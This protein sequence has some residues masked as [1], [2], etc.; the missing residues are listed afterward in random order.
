MEKEA[1]TH[2]NIL[3]WTIPGT[4]EPDGLKSMG[5]QRAGH[6]W[7]TEH[8]TKQEGRVPKRRIFCVCNKMGIYFKQKSGE[9]YFK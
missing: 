5:S 4:E 9:I 8:I 6:S 3:A 2:S 7:A 1:A